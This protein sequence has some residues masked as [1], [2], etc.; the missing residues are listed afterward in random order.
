MHSPTGATVA[1][2]KIVASTRS[3]RHFRDVGRQTSQEFF[4]V[5]GVGVQGN[6]GSIFLAEQR[7]WRELLNSSDAAFH[8]T[9][10]RF[11]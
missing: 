7:L 1:V 4:G 3:D 11:A 2:Q 9:L 6:A 5:H 8:S 10:P